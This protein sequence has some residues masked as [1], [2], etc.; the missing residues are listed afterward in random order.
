MSFA[1]S[2]SGLNGA[3]RAIDV[4]GNNIAN[5]QTI[6]FKS[7][8]ARFADVY[9]S[10][11]SGGPA[12]GAP[13]AGVSTAVINQQFTQ[14]NL[15]Q[16]ENPLD[17]AITGQGF[18]RL[19]NNGDVSYSR[20]GQFQLGYDPDF[21]DQRFLISRTGLSVTGYL[22]EYTTDPQG[23]IVTTGKPQHISIDP[24]MPAAATS[25]VTVGATLDARAPV[26]AA[27]FDLTN[28]ATYN[29]TTAV[30][31]YDTAGASHEL[32]MYFVKSAP[33]NLWDMYS[34]MDGAGQTGP[35]SLSFDTEGVMT[36]A[37]PLAAQTYPLGS[38]GSMSVTLDFRGTV[39]YGRSF[40]VDSVTQDGYR[41]GTVESSREFSVG[42]D[43]IIEAHYSNGQPRKVAQIVL[44]SFVNPDAL[45]SIGDNQ[46]I[47]NADPLMGTGTVI[48]DTPG[49]A[50]G[51]TPMGLG[52]IQGGAKE[53]SNVDLSTELV[54]LIEQQRNYQASAQT[55]KILD[56][57]LQDLANVR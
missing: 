38:G 31:A 34:T 2:L 26:P 50:L 17:M 7:S 9:A 41:S 11:I 47:E 23:V 21:P 15:M 25:T 6:G 29:N 40:S 32:R 1:L 14:G 43:G 37:M 51:T 56:Q 55:F 45:I 36:T 22:A 19:S 3:S 8:K 57:I 44:A 39:Q 33:G 30:T 4:I 49:R 10:S 28:S 16:S 52:P 35:V 12:G 24:N 27:P 20:D 42:A 5:S 48:L 46:W 53:Q 18:F 13:N 54:A